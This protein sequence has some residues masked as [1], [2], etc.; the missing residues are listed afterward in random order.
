MDYLGS[1]CLN[2]VDNHPLHHAVYATTTKK[3]L[4]SYCDEQLII[5]IAFKQPV[6]IYSLQIVAPDDGTDKIIAG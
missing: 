5:S 2:Y 1:E 3:F 4:E 6:K